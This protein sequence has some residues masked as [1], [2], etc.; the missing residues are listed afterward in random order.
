MCICYNCGD[1]K[2]KTEL[3]L[4]ERPAAHNFFMAKSEDLFENLG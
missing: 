2:E 4:L 3:W 1:S